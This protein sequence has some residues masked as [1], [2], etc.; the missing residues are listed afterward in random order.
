MYSIRMYSKADMVK[1][2]GVLTAHDEQV[3]LVKDKLSDSFRVIE[4]GC[5]VCDI[6]HY[7]TINPEFLFSTMQ[8]R[9]TK[10]KNIG[11]V[12]FLPETLENSIH[13]PRPIQ[14]LYYKYVLF[15]YRQMD[16][17]VTVNPYFID[18]LEKKY[19]FPRS[20][21]TY[22]PNVVST[23]RFYP[24]N[25][26]DKYA[27]RKHFQLPLDTFIVLCAGQLQKRKGVI[28]FIEIAKHMPDLHFVWAGDFSFG[29]IS[30]DYE[31]IKQIVVNPP[32]N[33]TFLG[34][35]DH[36]D[37]NL[38]YNACNMMLLPSY[39]ELFPMTI[40][41]AMNCHLPILVRNLD[42]YEE[43]LFD[44]VKYA[45]TV[46]EFVSCIRRLSE[47]LSFYDSCC[48]SSE[49]GSHHYSEEAV[50]FAWESYYFYILQKG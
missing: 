37:M 45:N 28:D 21:V 42:I 46:E 43:I 39:E 50:S 26:T 44:Y 5:E 9:R 31:Q 47:D 4:N 15:F 6:N 20:K 35:I 41:E 19:K 32:K 18:V 13:L 30:Q 34:L 23:K 1:G 3:A 25:W 2:H 33:V 14:W 17:L 12:H 27:A 22:I 24:M 49:N 16:A 38:L 48:K 8:A 7:H 40:L 36:S 11:Y 10:T 29:K